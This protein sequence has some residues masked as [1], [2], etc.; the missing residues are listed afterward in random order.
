MGINRSKIKIT[1]CKTH[2]Q[3]KQHLVKTKCCF[4][5]FLGNGAGKDD[6]NCNLSKYKVVRV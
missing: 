5:F 2:K 1:K 4:F 6:L 3:K